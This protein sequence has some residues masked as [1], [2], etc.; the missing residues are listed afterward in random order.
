MALILAIAFNLRSVILAVPPVLPQ[1]RADLHISFATAGSLTSLPVLCLGMM[2]LP[3]AWAVHRFGAK[4]VIGVCTM[5]IAAGALIRLAPPPLPALFFGTLVLSACVAMTQ[6]A[7]AA[8]IRD[9]FPAQIQRASVIY[10]V[11]LNL[12]GVLATTTTIYLALLG[13]WRGTFVIWAVPTVLAGAAWFWLA[14]PA[15]QLHRDPQPTRALLQDPGVFRAAGLFG[16]QSVVYFTALTWIPFLLESQGRRAIALTLLTMGL[17]V[18]MASLAL[19]MIH[20]PFATSRSFYLVAGAMTAIGALGL[21]LRWPGVSLALVALLGV[22]SGLT[23]TASMALPPLSAEG[24]TV[25]SYSALMLTAGYGLA[26]LG[27]YAGGV[28]VDA[29][30]AVSAPF[31]ILV[32]AGIAMAG[33]GLTFR[34]GSPD[35]GLQSPRRGE[36]HGSQ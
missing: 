35:N 8:V 4:G 12:G 23:F 18:V 11:A 13:G 5:G 16:S 19:A 29:T 15:G 34:P 32:L 3:G 6:P 27:P 25:A 30:R 20:R 21:A 24:S 2:A 9:W 17:T 31:W 10:T 7:A 14:P 1:M 22:G 28:L 36:S 33:L 26:F